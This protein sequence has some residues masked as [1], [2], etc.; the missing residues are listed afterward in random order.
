MRRGKV[1]FWLILAAFVLALSLIMAWATAGKAHAEGETV[2]VDQ[3]TCQDVTIHGAGYTPGQT[4]LVFAR[5][6]Q[7]EGTITNPTEV[8][9]DDEGMLPTTKLAFG[10]QVPDGTYLAVVTT[11]GQGQQEEVTAQFEVRGCL[12]GQRQVSAKADCQ[13]VTV[14]GTGF[15]RTNA[16]V[17]AVVLGEGDMTKQVFP[18]AQGRFTAVIPW[19]SPPI[20]GQRTVEGRIDGIKRAEANFAAPV[21]NQLPFTGLNTAQSWLLGII[22]LLAGTVI[23]LLQRRLHRN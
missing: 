4:L 21:C 18:D 2:A 7:G 10:G 8:K 13:A 5:A 9:A 15:E 22:L 14:T 6:P 1:M 23:L 19:S 17:E 16:T 11:P 20:G 3:V 12:A